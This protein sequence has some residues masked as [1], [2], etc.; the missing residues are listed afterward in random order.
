MES[1]DKKYKIVRTV[2]KTDRVVYQAYV[3]KYRLFG[4]FSS[5]EG[6]SYDGKIW[7]YAD[8]NDNESGAKK[9]IELHKKGNF[10]VSNVTEKEYI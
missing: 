8:K 9:A 3:K 7:Y 2:Y 1:E 5:W 4:L 10:V 6:L